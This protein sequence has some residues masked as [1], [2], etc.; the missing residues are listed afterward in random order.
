MKRAA[1]GNKIGFLMAMHGR[2]VVLAPAFFFLLF[3]LA[4]TSRLAAASPAEAVIS[5]EKPG[6][7]LDQQGA[8]DQI[9]QAHAWRGQLGQL[10]V[11]DFAASWCAPC[12]H[13]L[14]K[15]QA[16][17]ESRPGLRVLVVSVDQEISGRDQLVETLDLHL[18]VLWDSDHA[19]AQHY[20][21]EAMPT[22]LVLDAQGAE[23]LRVVGSGQKAWRQLTAFL[24]RQLSGR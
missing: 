7:A 18:P 21:P 20:H 2:G 6:T 17:A 3:V 13:S 9:G 10:T 24:D 14:P 11:I 15:L 16:Y 5:P 19:I 4:G 8:L 23:L 1:R 12:R 22:S